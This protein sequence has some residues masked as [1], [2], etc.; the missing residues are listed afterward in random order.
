M[1]FIILSGMSGAGKTQASNALED[2]GYY[3]IENMPAMLIREFIRVYSRAAPKFEKVALISDIRGEQEFDTLL[4]EID[5]I[6]KAA[7]PAAR[8]K[9]SNSQTL[10]PA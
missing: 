6:K 9:Y 10:R 4:G 8:D 1:E 2:S 7:T 3:C 5:D